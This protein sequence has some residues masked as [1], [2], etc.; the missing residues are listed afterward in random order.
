MESCPPVIGITGTGHP[1]SYK[2]FISVTDNEVPGGGSQSRKW[3][4]SLDCAAKWTLEEIRTSNWTSTMIIKNHKKAAAKRPAKHPSGGLKIHR[5]CCNGLTNRHSVFDPMMT[6]R[7]R[8]MKNYDEKLWFM[9]ARKWRNL[10]DCCYKSRAQD[11]KNIQEDTVSGRP[12][13]KEFNRLFA[14]I[15]LWHHF[16]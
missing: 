9:E 2:S 7:S 6:K 11:T 16:C 3:R 13:M 1:S 8:K 15:D 4:N 5:K 14:Q 10:L 12:K